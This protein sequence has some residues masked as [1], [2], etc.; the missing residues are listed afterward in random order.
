MGTDYDNVGEDYLFTKVLPWKRYAERFTYFK[1]VGAVAGLRMIDVACGDGYYTRLFR[2]Q[3]AEIVGVDLSREM[4]RLAREQEQREPQG[5]RYEVADGADLDAFVRQ[6]GLGEF[7]VSVSQ[8]M[9]D[10]AETREMLQG[11]CRSLARVTR[12]GGR[13][14]YL[15]GCFDSL[16]NHP[17]NFPRYGVAVEVLESHG[18]GSRIRWTLRSQDPAV[19]EP[20]MSAENTMWT[21]DTITAELEAAGFAD[22]EW[23]PVEVGSEGLAAVGRDYWPDFLKHPY[24]A[25]F[26]AARRGE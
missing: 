3:G 6:T 9:L 12:P 13:F 21:P 1:A 23:P 8:W 7:D 10:Y 16:L 18:D 5:I 2:E 25:V 4:I 17:E 26:S 15:G 14:V 19:D 20:P 11:M 22:I 24:F